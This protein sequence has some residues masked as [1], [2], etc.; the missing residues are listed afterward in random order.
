V[1]YLLMDKPEVYGLPENPVV[2]QRKKI[3]SLG[4]R[5]TTLLFGLAALMSFR[6]RGTSEM[7]DK[8]GSEVTK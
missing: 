7:A 1:F 2:P 5:F 6:E 3:S 4:T 8:K